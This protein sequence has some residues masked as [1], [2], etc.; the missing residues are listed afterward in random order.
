MT[1]MHP[2]IH[3]CTPHAPRDALYVPDI[4]HRMASRSEREE[5][6]MT[7]TSMSRSDSPQTDA[8]PPAE[9]DHRFWQRLVWPGII[10]YLLGGRCC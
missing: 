8:D 10:F 4:D 3:P 9:T 1:C 7:D 2:R 6:G 5:S